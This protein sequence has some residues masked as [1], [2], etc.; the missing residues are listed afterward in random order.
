MAQFPWLQLAATA[1]RSTNSGGGSGKFPMS[2]E[3]KVQGLLLEIFVAVLGLPPHSAYSCLTI[4]L[5]SS[6]GLKI[7]DMEE[8]KWGKVPKLHGALQ[9]HVGDHLEVLSNGLY[10]S[11]VQRAI[12]NCER[13]RISIVSLMSLGLDEKMGTAK[14]FVDEQHPKRYKESSFGDFLN[15]L[16][17]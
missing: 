11:V 5:Q 13:T 3:S 17:Q 6:P 8:G 9:V 7:M 15:S 16:R 14:E 1:F 4:A 10:K 12:L 2:L